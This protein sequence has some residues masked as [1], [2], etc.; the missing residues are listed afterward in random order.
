MVNDDAMIIIIIIRNICC[1]GVMRT[2]NEWKGESDEMG[3]V[4]VNVVYT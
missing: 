3:R 1:N 2:Q 4:E